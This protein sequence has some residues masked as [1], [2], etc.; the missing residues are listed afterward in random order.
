MGLLSSLIDSLRDN[1][2]LSAISYL[3]TCLK[4]S[5]YLFKLTFN[6]ISLLKPA[7]VNRMTRKSK[8]KGL[9]LNREQACTEEKSIPYA[10]R[11]EDIGE[12]NRELSHRKR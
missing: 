4:N 6:T 3:K 1:D 11:K 10:S 2:V 7:D 8:Q 9:Q 12:A 5:S